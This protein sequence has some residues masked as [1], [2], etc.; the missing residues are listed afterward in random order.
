M[1]Y[2]RKGLVTLVFSEKIYFCNG[3]KYDVSYSCLQGKYYLFIEATSQFYRCLAPLQPWLYY[4]LE[5]YEGP[6]K[7]V[8]VF[9]SAAYMVSKGTDVMRKAR[10]WKGAFWKLL[11]NVVINIHYFCCLCLSV[12]I[13]HEA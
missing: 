4:L 13:L 11:Q 10:L 1:D 5:S 7:V 2:D 12:F 9:L 3:Q 8:A 6:E